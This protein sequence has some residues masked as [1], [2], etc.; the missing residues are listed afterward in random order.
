LAIDPLAV[1]ATE[2]RANPPNILRHSNS[3]ERAEVRQS[4]VQ[5]LLR[6]VRGGARHVVPCVVRVHVCLDAA[7][8]DRVDGDPL[9]AEI[10]GKRAGEALDGAFGAGV[11]SMV[12]DSLHL[13]RHAAHEDDASAIFD[14]VVCCL[15]DEELSARVEVE[16]LVVLFWSD[17]AG[18]V[19]GFHARV[20]DGD[21]DTAKVVF[22][23]LVERRHLDGIA[24]IGLDG[25]SRLSKSLDLI[26]DL[27]GCA[28]GAGIVDDEVGAAAGKFESD[29]STDS[30]ARASDDSDF[31][32]EA[33][34]LNGRHF[35]RWLGVSGGGFGFGC[36]NDLVRCGG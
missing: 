33:G 16:D 26:N 30:T 11:Q 32:V 1:L 15:C 17:F 24:D 7:W 25:N 14:E 31:S 29:A 34:G 20:G 19:E 8:C 28:G 2:V 5:L 27:L 35:G 22:G 36:D 4:K 18:L 10:G 23:G 3:P 12:L 21:V 6:R 9:V 13:R